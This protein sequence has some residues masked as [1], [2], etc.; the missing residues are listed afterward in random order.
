[1]LFKSALFVSLAASALAE[2]AEPVQADTVILGTEGRVK[3]AVAGNTAVLGTEGTV[4]GAVSVLDDVVNGKKEDGKDG[5][6]SPQDQALLQNVLSLLHKTEPG[7]NTVVL[8]S[9]G[10]VNGAVSGLD[11]ILKMREATA[12]PVNEKRDNNNDDSS[13]T[14][15]VDVRVELKQLLDNLLNGG[16][17]PPNSRPPL[18]L[19]HR[20]THQYLNSSYTSSQLGPLQNILGVVGLDQLFSGLLGNLGGAR[21]GNVGG[22]LAGLGRL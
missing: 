17:S 5:S 7:L 20:A 3:G 21:S 22:L 14:A 13:I 19:P 9:E 18:P 12:A 11:G 8:G 16:P 1:M 15:D 6:P 2:G 10:T 4:N